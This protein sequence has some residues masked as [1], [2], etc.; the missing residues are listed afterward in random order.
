MLTPFEMFN[1]G[2]IFID[3]SERGFW[4]TIGF[5]SNKN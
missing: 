3:I 2:Q 5:V 1:T 4:A